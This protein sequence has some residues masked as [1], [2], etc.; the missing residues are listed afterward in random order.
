MARAIG[1]SWLCSDMRR[2]S[3]VDSAPAALDVTVG[4]RPERCRP[5]RPAA[6]RKSRKAYTKGEIGRQARAESR[7]TP[8]PAAG[9]RPPCV[10]GSNHPRRDCCILAGGSRRANFSLTNFVA[11]ALYAHSGSKRYAINSIPIARRGRDRARRVEPLQHCSRTSRLRP[12][13]RECRCGVRRSGP[14]GSRASGGGA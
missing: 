7:P 2:S 3:L 9:E 11:V 6:A 1:R 4:A 8:F 12:R 5:C 10:F 13:Y 14:G